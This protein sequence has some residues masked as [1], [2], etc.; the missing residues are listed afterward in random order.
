MSAV[1]CEVD[2]PRSLDSGS[3]GVPDSSFRLGAQ[4]RSQRPQRPNH[5]W[6]TVERNLWLGGLTS[7]AVPPSVPKDGAYSLEETTCALDSEPR[8]PSL[9]AMLV[10][11][12]S[13]ASGGSGGSCSRRS[14]STEVHV[15]RSRSEHTQ[16]SSRESP[17][18]C[19][20]DSAG[21]RTGM[22]SSPTVVMG[23]ESED[24]EYLEAVSSCSTGSGRRNSFGAPV[25]VLPDV[26]PADVGDLACEPLSSA[27]PSPPPPTPRACSARTESHRGSAEACGCST[28]DDGE[29]DGAEAATTSG[30]SQR[31]ASSVDAAVMDDMTE[32]VAQLFGVRPRQDEPPEQCYPF[33]HDVKFTLGDDRYIEVA[34]HKPPK[35]AAG[36]RPKQ[37]A[38]MFLPGVHGGVGPCRSEGAT[39]DEHA[40]FP[41]LA[42]KLSAA[43][44]HCYRVSW[45][46]QS[47]TIADV[48][49]AL[50]ALAW[51][52]LRGRKRKVIF[53]GHSLGGS[54]AMIVSEILRRSFLEEPGSWPKGAQIAGVCTLASAM[55]GAHLTSQLEGIPKL[56]F[57]GTADDVVDPICADAFYKFSAQPS[58]LQYLE[59][60]G[61]DM[62]SHKAYLLE[63]IEKWILS[64]SGVRP[65]SPQRR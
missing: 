18:T 41:L 61:H 38:V 57:H 17:D 35:D 20:H 33:P 15:G 22:P 16:E 3:S 27:P 63:K 47:P 39:Y 26:A 2:E 34:C 11:E 48:V 24:G 25:P 44:M 51:R 9:T 12:L 31:L 59:G 7:A 65:D 19:D 23:S 64:C 8:C 60:C 53:V 46:R 32:A 1:L 40:L 14:W 28:E 56:F 55:S 4:I 54:V 6:D 13:V 43:G 50:T 42:K 21:A 49:E 29:H 45:N 30:P 36:K 62:L 10:A 52:V 58:T 5:G 37:A